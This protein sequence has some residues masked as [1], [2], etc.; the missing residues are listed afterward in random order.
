MKDMQEE[1]ILW[2]VY[3][4]YGREV[5]YASEDIDEAGSWAADYDPRHLGGTH[6]REATD[7]ERL[8]YQEGGLLTDAYMKLMAR[9]LAD[10]L[11]VTTVQVG[12]YL[13]RYKSPL[14]EPGAQA[15]YV[16]LI[17]PAIDVLENFILA[18]PDAPGQ[19]GE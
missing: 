19:G 16:Q 10:R 6:V 8:L 4:P 14:C 1:T 11:G 5:L 12:K 9:T 13:L 7:D 2:V 17:A 15:V 18:Q 3:D